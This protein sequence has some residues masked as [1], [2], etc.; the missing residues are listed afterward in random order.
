MEKKQVKVTEKNYVTEFNTAVKTFMAQAPGRFS[1]QKRVSKF[2]PKKL[3][4]ID[5]RG[6]SSL[7]ILA[8]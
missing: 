4:E 6:P 1:L 5:P 8:A 3:Y 7:S 2:T